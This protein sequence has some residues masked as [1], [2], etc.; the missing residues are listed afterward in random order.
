MSLA[1]KVFAV[2]NEFFDKNGKP[3]YM[4]DNYFR[5]RYYRFINVKERS[6]RR[7]GKCAMPGC[8]NKC[9]SSHTIPESSV[10]KRIA[11][12]K[13]V[14][15]PKYNADINAYECVSIKT[16]KASVFPGF[17][18]KHENWFSGFEKNGNFYDPSMA[19]QNL[20]IICRYY[21]AWDSL[22]KVFERTLLKYR[23]EIEDY[24]NEKIDL[25]NTELGTDV[26]LK[27]VEDENTKHMKQQIAFIRSQMTHIHNNDLYPFIKTM[28]GDGDYVSVIAVDVNIELPACLAGK[29]EFVA[30][31]KKYTVHLSVFPYLNGTFC[32]FSVNKDS[33]EHF[34][35]LLGKYK[36]DYEFIGFIES[37]ICGTSINK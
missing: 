3:R 7:K 35:R 10:L 1:S 14:F 24:Q 33:E 5:A 12:A 31:D 30:G 23:K 8:S 26:T 22:L 32:C 11:S 17:C 36:D 20:R 29:S 28:E 19:I 4:D 37:G 18:N 13:D 27:S 9:V 34:R 25:L 2:D 15:Y 21:F 6:R 16:K